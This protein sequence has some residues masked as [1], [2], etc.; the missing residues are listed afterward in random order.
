M[1]AGKLYAA[2]CGQR[3][4]AELAHGNPAQGP[5]SP[6]T[7]TH[8]IHPMDGNR[9]WP[10]LRFLAQAKQW[11]RT[12]ARR[13]DILHGITAF[14]MTAAPAC[15]AEALGLPAVVK[16][17]SHDCDL[18]RHRGLR[19]WFS[20]AAR[21]RQWAKRWSGVIALTAA[22]EEEL[23]ACGVHPERITRIPNAVDTRR[24]Q[25]GDRGARGN[26]RQR[27]GLPD[28]PLVAFCGVMGDR[29]RPHLVLQALQ[30]LSDWHAVMVGPFADGDSETRLR[31]LAAQ[32]GGRVTFIGMVEDPAPYLRAADVYC[33]PS[34]QEGQPNSVLEALA[35]GLPCVLTAFAGAGELVEPDFGLVVDPVPEALSQALR[36]MMDRGV[37]ASVAARRFAEARFSPGRILDL[38]QALF[39]RV[40]AGR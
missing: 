4:R 6:F 36:S 39:A 27:L 35:C 34:L 1:A 26:L 32:V 25:P 21:R 2:D 38:H 31:Q 14:H 33:L 5:A 18:R 10:Y 12:N 19:A 23:L 13:F 29:K 9:R 8:L 11:L 24:F 3:F 37:S 22:I 16:V 7:S 30:H 17:S 15:W 28:V 20:A 40:R